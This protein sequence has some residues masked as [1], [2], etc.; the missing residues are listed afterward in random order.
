MY[1]SARAEENYW[2]PRWKSTEKWIFKSSSGKYN[3]LHYSNI[4]IILMTNSDHLCV[5]F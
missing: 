5:D 1:S 4:L 3:D 2:R